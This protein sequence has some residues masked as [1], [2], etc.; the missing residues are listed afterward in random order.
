MW[1]YS[2]AFAS[3]LVAAAAILVTLRGQ[4]AFV[5][6]DSGSSAPSSVGIGSANV[7]AGASVN[8]ELTLQAPQTGVGAVTVDILYSEELITA[9]SCSVHVKPGACNADFQSG[10]VRLSLVSDPPL[11]DFVNLATIEFRAGTLPGSSSLDVIVVQLT[12]PAYQ[13]IA[14][15]DVVDGKDRKSV[16]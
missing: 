2:R 6:N 12:D 5:A 16:V 15:N 3:C 8:V 10:S 13:D 1:Q 4:P 7:Q 14:L 11:R 9:T